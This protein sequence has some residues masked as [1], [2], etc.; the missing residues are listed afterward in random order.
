MRLMKTDTNCFVEDW[1]FAFTPKNDV[2]QP[3]H[4][5][6]RFVISYVISGLESIESDLFGIYKLSSRIDRFVGFLS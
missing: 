5:E 1:C 4:V 2:G 3:F 6:Y